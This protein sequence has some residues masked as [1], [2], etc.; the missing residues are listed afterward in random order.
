MTRQEQIKKIITYLEENEEAAI[1][2]IEQLD[3]YNGFLDY[4]RYYNMED[5]PMFYENDV[6]NLLDRIYFGYDEDYSTTDKTTK[7][8]PMRDYFKY[9]GYGNLVS[10]SEKDYSAFIDE[11][12][13][14]EL[15]DHRNDIYEIDDNLDLS[16]LFDELEKITILEAD[17]KDL[18]DELQEETDTEE[19][20]D[21]QEQIKE[22]EKELEELE[23]A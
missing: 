18:K 3:D 14:E 8:N 4:N 21:L 12:L 7:F 20:K 22:L 13:I 9:S 15:E 19:Q 10:S 23:E 16:V 17:I 6:E 2:C 5:L 1:N 11:Y